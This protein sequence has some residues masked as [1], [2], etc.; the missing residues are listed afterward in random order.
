MNRKLGNTPLD[1]VPIIHWPS[2]QGS[3][4]KGRPASKMALKIRRVWT[5]CSNPYGDFNTSDSLLPTR[6]PRCWRLD[7]ADAPLVGLPHP[8]STAPSLNVGAIYHSL[9]IPVLHFAGFVD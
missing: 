1:L 2:S 7:L 8:P 5:N 3:E 9:A 4:I 6:P